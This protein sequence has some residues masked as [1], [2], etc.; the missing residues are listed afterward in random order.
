MWNHYYHFL[1]VDVYFL[2]KA[3]ERQNKLED[4]WMC[5]PFSLLNA[6]EDKNIF[7]S[8]LCLLFFSYLNA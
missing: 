2:V 7:I 3:M 5:I 1:T 4:G 6:N 8:M